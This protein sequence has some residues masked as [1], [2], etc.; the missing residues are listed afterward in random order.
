[1]RIILI[2]SRLQM[3]RSLHSCSKYKFSTIHIDEYGEK[4]AFKSKLIMNLPGH[5]SIQVHLKAQ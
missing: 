4:E 1:M 2:F 5:E 3:P